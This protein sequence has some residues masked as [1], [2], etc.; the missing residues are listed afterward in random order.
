MATDP[1]DAGDAPPAGGDDARRATR[2]TFA[3]WRAEMAR[4]WRDGGA[5]YTEVVT[6]EPADHAVRRIARDVRP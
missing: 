2:A 6:D 4:A 3:V 1:E 5:G